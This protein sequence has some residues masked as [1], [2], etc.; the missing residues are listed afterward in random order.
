MGI[1]VYR[2]TTTIFLLTFLHLDPLGLEEVP[3]LVDLL[4][5][6]P[7]ELG[8]GVLVHHGLADDLLRPIGV[9]LEVE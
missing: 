4:L 8:V 7:D 2:S 3:Q 6:L 9:P 1:F 5:Q